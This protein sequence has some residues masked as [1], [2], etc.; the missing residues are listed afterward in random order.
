MQI[1][2]APA[3]TMLADAPMPAGITPTIPRF[4]Q[5]ADM[6]ASRMAGYT[7]AELSS[8]LKIRVP[9]AADVYRLYKDFPIAATR[10]PAAVSY[11]GIAFKYLD[12]ASLS[13]ADMEWANSRL[14]ICSFLYGMLRP[15]D[16][17]NPYRLEGKVH[18][19]ADEPDTIIESW[20]KYLTGELI[21]D[22]KA[23]GGIL[24]NL[25]SDEMKGLFDWKRV[26]AEVNVLTVKFKTGV[27]GHL[28][29]SSV[30]A[31]MCRGAMARYV[32]TNRITDPHM[33]SSWEF[34]G[35]RL[36]DSS[37]SDLTFAAIL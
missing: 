18:Y 7:V 35:F 27:F 22:V 16:L 32:I 34:N 5:R 14:T 30:Y 37:S 25:A 24:L 33:L 9:M 10:R 29:T 21:R 11:N 4:Q 17:I 6:I 36:I 23:D 1:L 3:K 31:K 2:L 12:F 15:L 13:P 19:P 8:I 26:C 20:R 28:R